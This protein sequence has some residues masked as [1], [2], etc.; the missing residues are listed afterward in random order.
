EH[1]SLNIT[2][3]SHDATDN[4]KLSIHHG[5]THGYQQIWTLNM[6]YDYALSMFDGVDPTI[7]IS[8]AKAE[9]GTLTASYTAPSD[10]SAASV[11]MY[12][13]T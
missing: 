1:F 6:I 5:L 8:D 7:T 12:Y 9:N 4:A 2:T 11:T 3:L 13:I 10:T